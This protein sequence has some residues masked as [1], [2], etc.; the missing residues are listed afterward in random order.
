MEEK[1]RNLVYDKGIILLVEK[2]TLKSDVETNVVNH[3]EDNKIESISHTV[4]KDKIWMDW[5]PNCK[6]ETF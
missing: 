1:S 2:K 3:M 5:R 6:N 4:Q